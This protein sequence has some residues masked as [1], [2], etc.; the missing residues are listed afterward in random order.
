MPSWGPPSLVAACFIA[1]HYLF[2]RAA[3]GRI[4]DRL[5]ALVLEGSAAIGIAIAYLVGSKTDVPTT[6]AGVVSAVVSGACISGA[7]ILMFA[8]LRKGAPVATI[9]TIV[10]G[11][12]VALSAV[13]APWLF[14]EAFTVRRAI[15]VA[16]GLAA[17]AVLSTERGP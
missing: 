10:L 2:M 8:V 9:G 16:L 7:S 13:A 3:S 1:V 14:G 4:G 17:M 12:G 11:G 6:R 15:G 5:G